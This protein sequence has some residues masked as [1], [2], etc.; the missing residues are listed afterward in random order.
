MKINDITEIKHFNLGTINQNKIVIQRA[1]G[2]AILY[3]SYNTLVGIEWSQNGYNR[4]YIS[5]N[6]WTKTTG[7]LLNKLEPNKDKRKNTENFKMA[8]DAMFAFLNS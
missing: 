4:K 8:T 1:N 7:K 5:H 2:G 6:Y 3:F